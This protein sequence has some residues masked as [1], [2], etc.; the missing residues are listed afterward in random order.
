MMGLC[1]V[2][3]ARLKQAIV[4]HR[5]FFCPISKRGLDVTTAVAVELTDG[6]LIGPY[7]LPGLA[8]V[9]GLPEADV[10][11]AILETAQQVDKGA[12]LLIGR[13][14]FGKGAK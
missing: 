5:T 6:Q 8:A 7:N 4:G 14:L 10:L 11:A 9:R 1:Y 2:D 3:K 12:R 13:D